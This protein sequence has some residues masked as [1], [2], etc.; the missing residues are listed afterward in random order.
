MYA[1][2]ELHNCAGCKFFEKADDGENTLEEYRAA[3]EPLCMHPSV[4][5]V[6]EREPEA[7]MLIGV[8]LLTV[9]RL[10]LCPLKQR[11]PPRKIGDVWKDK[12][13]SAY[14]SR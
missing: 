2:D 11:K 9:N 6:N 3:T 14:R 12:D 10:S 1:N 5:E 4:L 13:K 8:L 7:A